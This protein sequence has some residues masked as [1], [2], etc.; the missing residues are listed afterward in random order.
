MINTI[1]LCFAA[2]TIAL[3]SACATPLETTLA[4]GSVAYRIDCS[5]ARGLNYCFE[6]A[7]KSCGAEGYSIVGRGGELISSSNAA[8]SEQE[9]RVLAYQ[10]NRTSILVRC[11]Q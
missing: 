4:D 10:S 9:A 8:S 1:R 5:S 6:K 2:G 7:G 3:L 11:G